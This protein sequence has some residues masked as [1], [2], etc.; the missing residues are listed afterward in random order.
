MRHFLKKMIP[1]LLVIAM[2]ASVI[3]YFLIYDTTLTRDLLLQQARHFEQSGNT[4]AAVLLYN[5][6]YLQSGNN[7]AV[8]IEL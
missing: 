8:A 4:T 7:E 6:A 3:W 2:L 1:V 5:L